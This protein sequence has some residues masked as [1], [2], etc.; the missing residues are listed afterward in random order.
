MLVPVTA[1]WYAG[2][3][4][5]REHLEEV[6]WREVA[7]LVSLVRWQWHNNIFQVL[8]E[9]NYEK[10]SP[11]RRENETINEVGAQLPTCPHVK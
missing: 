4:T 6:D 1:P 11:R 10:N 5:Y 2:T 8:R 9:Q 3:P 7:L